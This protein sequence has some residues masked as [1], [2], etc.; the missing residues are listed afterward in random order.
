M[1]V[2]VCIKIDDDIQKPVDDTTTKRMDPSP[3]ARLCL[4]HTLGALCCSCKYVVILM[5]PDSSSLLF[6]QR[7]TTINKH[8][9][10]ARP[11]SV[12]NSVWHGQLWVDSRV[13][14]DQHNIVQLI[15]YIDQHLWSISSCIGQHLLYRSTFGQFGQQS[16]KVGQILSTTTR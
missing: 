13:T 3:L 16:V 7:S 10:T 1:M 5:G 11:T 4:Q 6:C 2:F 14:F 12:D 8:H 15:V 9:I